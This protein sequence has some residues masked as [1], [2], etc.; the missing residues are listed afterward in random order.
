M[1]V[2][3]PIHFQQVSAFLRLL[4]LSSKSVFVTKSAC[5]D[6]AVKVPAV[7]NFIKN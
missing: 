1:C 5:L 6:L 3:F 4:S 7:L 2:A